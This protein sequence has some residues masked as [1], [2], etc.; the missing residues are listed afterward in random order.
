VV[1]GN[2]FFS[3]STSEF[4]VIRGDHPVAQREDP[5]ARRVFRDYHPLANVQVLPEDGPATRTASASCSARSGSRRPS[6]DATATITPARSGDT[7][8]EARQG[9]LFFAFDKYQI[10]VDEQPELTRAG[11]GGVQ[12]GGG[13]RVRARPTS[14]R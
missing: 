10:M 8:T 9:G 1:S 14:T 12:P 11:S 13:R 2:D 7:L 4:W 5:D 3:P 6:G